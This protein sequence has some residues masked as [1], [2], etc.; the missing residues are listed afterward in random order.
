MA[1]A[2]LHF[3]G[4]YQSQSCTKPMGARTATAD[5]TSVPILPNPYMLSSQY[6]FEDDGS[7]AQLLLLTSNDGLTL[8][9]QYTFRVDFGNE[10]ALHTYPQIGQISSWSTTIPE[11]RDTPASYDLRNLDIAC[12]IGSICMTRLLRTYLTGGI[13]TIRPLHNIS[14]RQM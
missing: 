11:G 4:T 14:K 5:L 9:L 8:Q 13:C 2:C 12:R 6:R 10:T 7:V 3:Q 1:E